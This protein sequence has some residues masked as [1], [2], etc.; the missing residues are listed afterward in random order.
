MIES[1]FAPKDHSVSDL[2]LTIIIGV[3]I[4]AVLCFIIS[5]PFRS[6]LVPVPTGMDRNGKEITKHV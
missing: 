2:S 4:K 1:D 3:P 6:I 5:F